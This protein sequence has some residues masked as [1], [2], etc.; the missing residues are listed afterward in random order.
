[1]KQT[2]RD[3]D[4]KGKVVLVRTDYNVPVKDGEVTSDLRVSA[5][6][7]TINYLLEH[8]AKKIVLI[9]HLG[10]P[11]G[12]ALPEFSL[13][14]VAEVLEVLLPGNPIKFVPS[15][16]GSEVTGA[17]RG[18]NPR[19]IV[20]LENLRFSAL[21]E[22]NSEEYIRS[23]VEATGAEI[24]VQDGFAVV[25]R[26]HASTD[27]IARV[28][29]VYMGL[30]LEKEI[31]SLTKVTENPEHPL[32]VIIGGAK[33]ADKQPLIDRFLNIADNIIVG[34]KIA[35]D[36]YESDNEKIYVAED[37]DE[38]SDGK[39]MDCGPVATVRMAEILEKSKTV[40]WNGLLGYA[41]DPTYATS[42]TIVAKILGENPAIYSVICGG[43]TA[44]FVENLREEDDNLEYGLVS[45]GGGAALDFLCG[46]KLPGVECIADKA[47]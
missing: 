20:L 22:E 11:E 21:E 33:V 6:L 25:H 26:A 39:K 41:E 10:R 36:G 12:E 28:L 24:Y 34:G 46:K 18:E 40:I 16:S 27:A 14:P 30:L 43:D 15:V 1:M 31:K 4:V 44:G 42:S 45:T 7:P 29:P 13:R 32:T 5:S 17:C 37:F 38:T 8:E 35:A 47:E 3:V 2:I 23:I 19:E 9:S